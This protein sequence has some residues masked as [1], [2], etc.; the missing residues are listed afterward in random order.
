MPRR[1]REKAY[2]SPLLMSY[3]RAIEKLGPD[4]VDA[5]IQEGQHV[6]LKKVEEESVT[7]IDFELLKEIIPER[8]DE[9]MTHG[10]H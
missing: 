8:T 4:G 9:E 2:L 6:F 7:C 3:A 5:V 1:E 10:D